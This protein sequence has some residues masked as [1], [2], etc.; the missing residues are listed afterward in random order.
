MMYRH[1]LKYKQGQLLKHSK[2]PLV[3]RECVILQKNM[4]RSVS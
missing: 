3:K 4:S 2:L 1:Q